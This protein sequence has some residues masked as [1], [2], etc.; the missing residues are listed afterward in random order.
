MT[1][2]SAVLRLAAGSA[3]RAFSLTLLALL[4]PLSGLLCLATFLAR[5]HIVGVLL[6][7]ILILVFLVLFLVH[8]MSPFDLNEIEW[9]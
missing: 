1:N 5:E 8:R 4:T 7:L 3:L 6:I 2:S 9:G